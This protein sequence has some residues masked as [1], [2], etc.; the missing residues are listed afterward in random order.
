MKE[1]IKN[2][3]NYSVKFIEDVSLFIQRYRIVCSVENIQKVKIQKLQRQKREN[4]DFIKMG[5]M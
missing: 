3:K 2:L 5:S 4:N 1:K